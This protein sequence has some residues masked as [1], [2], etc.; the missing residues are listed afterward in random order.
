MK[1]IVLRV[2]CPLFFSDSDETFNFLDRFLRNTQMSNFITIR[3]V[4]AEFFHRDGQTHM[5]TLTVAL[6]NSVN[7]PKNP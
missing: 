3:P 5:K 7:S 6:H 2:K 4:G 1:D